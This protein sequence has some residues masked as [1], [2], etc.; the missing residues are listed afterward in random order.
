M[1]LLLIFIFNYSILQLICKF[2]IFIDLVYH[3]LFQ[4]INS[5]DLISIWMNLIFYH[6]AP[7][8]WFNSTKL[9]CIFILLHLLFAYLLFIF[10]S[11]HPFLFWIIHLFCLINLMLHLFDLYIKL[12]FINIIK[13]RQLFTLKFSLYSHFILIFL[14]LFH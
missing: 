1:K 3:S 9:I 13:I 11:I 10:N 8:T 7:Y 4:I 6:L 5:I 14:L 12:S 2:I